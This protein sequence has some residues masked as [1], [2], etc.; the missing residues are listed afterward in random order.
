VI[1]SAAYHAMASVDVKV[2]SLEI[3]IIEF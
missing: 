2:V 1:I 3:P